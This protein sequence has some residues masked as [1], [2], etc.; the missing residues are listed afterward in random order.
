MGV[1][2]NGMPYSAA[3]GNFPNSNTRLLN[4]NLPPYPYTSSTNFK[5]IGSSSEP[6]TQI[7]SR[8]PTATSSIT[9]SE[10]IQAVITRT[11]DTKTGQAIVHVKT[12]DTSKEEARKHNVTSTETP[13]TIETPTTTTY[14]PSIISKKPYKTFRVRN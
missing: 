1:Y 5:V 10:P 8:G 3:N 12:P 7:I 4:S 14:K 6:H 13:T 11:I 2:Q 9:K